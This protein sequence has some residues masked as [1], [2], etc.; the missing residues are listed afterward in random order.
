MGE[1]R[2]RVEN[3][4]TRGIP[5]SNAI[6]A[7]V[8][9]LIGGPFLRAMQGSEDLPNYIVLDKKDIEGL[10]EAYHIQDKPYSKEELALADRLLT[11]NPYLA[12]ALMQFQRL[13]MSYAR[14][15]LIQHPE[16]LQ[17]TMNT[18]SEIF[19]SVPTQEDPYRLIPNPKL[20]KSM[21]NN[22]LGAVARVLIADFRDVAPEQIDPLALRGQDIARGVELARELGL[23]QAEVGD[24][25]TEDGEARLYGAMKLTCPAM[26]PF[27][28]GGK[29]VLSVTFDYARLQQSNQTY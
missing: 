15:Y 10:I 24:F 25:R 2:E 20:L 1:H 11:E 9:K 6:T 23:F 5:L 19:I 14:Q 22:W 8:E 16:R 4:T 28:H 18:M 13:Y 21:A 26:V 12:P 7:D 3:E 27:T 29:E 17:F